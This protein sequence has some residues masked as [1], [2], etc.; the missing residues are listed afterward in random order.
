MIS[1]LKHEPTT[2][3]QSVTGGNQLSDFL[4]E[5]ASQWWVWDL[6]RVPDMHHIAILHNVIFALQTQS[7]L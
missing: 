3:A 6:P 2:E 5:S 1:V 7:T 4:R